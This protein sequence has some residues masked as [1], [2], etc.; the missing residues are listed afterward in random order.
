MSTFG[1]V[2]SAIAGRTTHFLNVVERTDSTGVYTWQ[3][4]GRPVCEEAISFEPCQHSP[5]AYINCN[6]TSVAKVDGKYELVDTRGCQPFL[7]TCQDHPKGMMLVPKHVDI[8][9]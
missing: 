4:N 9:A 8:V 3:A 1:Y 5:P 2:A 6:A 7:R